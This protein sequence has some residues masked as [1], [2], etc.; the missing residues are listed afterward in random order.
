MTIPPVRHDLVG[1]HAY[2]APQIDVPVRLNV[3]ENPFP[4]SPELVAT[5]AREVAQVAQQLNRYPDRDAVALRH[6]LAAYIMRESGGEISADNVWVANGSNEVMHHLFAA[7]GGPGRTVVT[8]AP[9]YSM[10][11]EYC[12]ESF[13]NFVTVS[14]DDEYAVTIPAIDAALALDPHIVVVCSP[15]NP[16]GTVLAPEVL[17]YLVANFKGLIIVDEAY[18]EFR[19]E[20]TQSAIAQYGGYSNVVITRTMSKAFSCAGLRLG[21]AIAHPDVVAAC[22]VVR[23]PYHLSA[24]SQA[25]AR[26][27]LSHADELL[28]QVDLLRKER[29]SLAKWLAEHNYAVIPSGANFLLFGTFADRHQIWQG[30]L[31]HGVLIRETGPAGWLRV[32][33]GTPDENS[34]FRT[35]L[36]TVDK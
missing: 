1:M 30:L 21:Y 31:D 20:G 23:L 6:D 5:I 26:A 32:S 33:I 11:E 34:A 27:A 18:G 8:F 3:N 17:D 4:P 28:S 12:R 15:N 14:R 7:F 19:A 9:T 29:D 22:T 24:V 13:T 36:I 2:G 10:Y 35:A 16:T 25:V